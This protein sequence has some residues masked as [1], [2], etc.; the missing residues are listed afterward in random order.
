MAEKVWGEW[1]EA[2]R[3]YDTNV[4]DAREAT[5]APSFYCL[6]RSFD[7]MSRCPVCG[8]RVECQQASLPRETPELDV[9]FAGEGDDDE[10]EA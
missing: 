8:Y 2:H 1:S 3:R 5:E 9:P 6:G 7:Q 10:V 4:C